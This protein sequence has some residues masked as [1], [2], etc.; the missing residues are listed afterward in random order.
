[1]NSVPIGDRHFGFRE[2]GA[3]RF[4]DDQLMIEY[5]YNWLLHLLRR[6]KSEKAEIPIAD[7]ATIQT[8]SFSIFGV[9]LR[10]RFHTFENIPMTMLWK[11][12]V[13]VKFEIPDRFRADGYSLLEAVSAT[14]PD[15]GKEKRPAKAV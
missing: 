10:M 7:L 9:Y 11:D 6:K 4:S 15:K 3:I 14:H 13:S 5:H 8:K 2:N 12:G 1:M